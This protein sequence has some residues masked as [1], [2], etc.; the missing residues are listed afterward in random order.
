MSRNVPYLVWQDKVIDPLYE[1]KPDFEI[2][3]LIAEKMGYGEFFDMDSEDFI[4]LWLDSDAARDLGITF[5]KLKEEKAARFLPGETYI[6]F[7][8]GSFTTPSKRA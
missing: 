2:Y 8:G 6:S 1:S 4:K 7:E 3:K 5:E